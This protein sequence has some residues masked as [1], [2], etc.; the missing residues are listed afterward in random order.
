MTLTQ[1][2][3]QN[4]SDAMSFITDDEVKRLLIMINGVI[5]DLH[6]DIIGS[7]LDYRHDHVISF[8][9]NEAFKS[10]KEL[11]LQLESLMGK[12]KKINE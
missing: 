6:K 3:F 11:V 10:A 2:I 7:D 4:Y 9:V 12:L 8:D 1:N 5:D